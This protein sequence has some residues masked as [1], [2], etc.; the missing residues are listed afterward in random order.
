MVERSL[1]DFY[2]HV[3]EARYRGSRH[4]GTLYIP[5][6]PAQSGELCQDVLGDDRAR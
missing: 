2:E 5:R 6:V 1:G 4:S 3:F